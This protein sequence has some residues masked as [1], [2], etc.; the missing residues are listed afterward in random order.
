VSPTKAN[1]MFWEESRTRKKKNGKKKW[2][3]AKRGSPKN[4]MGCLK[5]LSEGPLAPSERKGKKI[6]KRG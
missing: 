4:G 5:K 2:G 1:K 3:G 6:K